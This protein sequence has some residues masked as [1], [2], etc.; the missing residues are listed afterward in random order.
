MLRACQFVV[1]VVFLAGLAFACYRFPIDNLDRY[2]YEAVVRGKSEPVGAVY[3]VV[4][5]ES[6][7]AEQS[8]VLDSPQHLQ[9]LEPMYAIRPI[10]VA[11]ISAGSRVL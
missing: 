10:Y 11:A 3:A 2:I 9:E 6:P 5:H 8:S 4:K 7:R 1:C